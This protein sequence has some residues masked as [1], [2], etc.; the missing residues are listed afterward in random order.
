[1]SGRYFSLLFVYC[2]R[3]ESG[4]LMFLLRLMEGLSSVAS[5]SLRADKPQ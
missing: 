1:M 5:I 4:R 3:G 2:A